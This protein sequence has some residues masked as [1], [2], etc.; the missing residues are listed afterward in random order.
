MEQMKDRR[1]FKI[2]TDALFAET[3][4]KAMAWA[5]KRLDARISRTTYGDRSPRS[6]RDVQRVFGTSQKSGT[7]ASNEDVSEE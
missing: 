7:N 5:N 6:L 1:Q 4:Q 2:D 3:T